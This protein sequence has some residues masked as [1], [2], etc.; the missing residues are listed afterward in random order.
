VVIGAAFSVLDALAYN[1][2]REATILF[3]IA[4]DLA[5]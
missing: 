2:A 4:D 5:V 3:L 1:F